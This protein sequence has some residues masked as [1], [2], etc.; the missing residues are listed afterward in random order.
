MDYLQT[1]VEAE[2]CGIVTPIVVEFKK[3]EFY[4]GLRPVIKWIGLDWRKAYDRLRGNRMTADDLHTFQTQQDGRKRKDVYSTFYEVRFCIVA[5]LKYMDKTQKEKA[6]GLLTQLNGG[7]YRNFLTEVRLAKQI[8]DNKILQAKNEALQNELQETIKTANG[9]Y[10]LTNDYSNVIKTIIN[11]VCNAIEEI[12][13]DKSSDI[14]NRLLMALNST[15]SKDEYRDFVR[16]ARAND[17]LYTLDYAEQHGLGPIY[18]WCLELLRK[19]QII[20]VEGQEEGTQPL[21]HGEDIDE[22]GH[23]IEEDDNEEGSKE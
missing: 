7:L 4:F 5:L 9:F 23:E 16:D 6:N 1:Y 13:E 8:A 21:Y 20:T 14:H 10:K 3:D 18:S 19:Y 22:D 12:V 17:L 2:L 15:V 11:I